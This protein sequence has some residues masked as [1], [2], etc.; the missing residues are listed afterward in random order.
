V[1]EVGRIFASVEANTADFDRKMA[2][3]ERAF[4]Q[5][6]TKMGQAGAQ[7]DASVQ[8][9]LDVAQKAYTDR[10]VAANNAAKAEIDIARRVM[11]ERIK[12]TTSASEIAAVREQY[13]RRAAAA[14]AGA[15][16]EIQAAQQAFLSSTQAMRGSITTIGQVGATATKSSVG[17]NALRSSMTTLAANALSS[18][19]G[20]AQFGSV[21]GTMALGAPAMIAILAGLAA[22]GVAVERIGR[23][24]R[25]AAKESKAAI[26]SLLADAAK[27]ADPTGVIPEL[28]A[29]RAR[30]EVLEQSLQRALNPAFDPALLRQGISKRLAVDEKAVEKI[31][32]EIGQ[33]NLAIREGETQVIDWGNSLK[34]NA[35]K[36][37]DAIE[38]LNQAVVKLL[39]A[40]IEK[41]G[42]TV[43]RLP[44]LVDSITGSGA[45]RQVEIVSDEAVRRAARIGALIREGGDSLKKRIDQ[46]SEKFD[47]LIA[48]VST[49]GGAFDTLKNLGSGLVLD[50]LAGAAVNLV[51]DLFSVSE[52]TRALEAAQRDLMNS[53]R[54]SVARM[55]AELL[56]PESLAKFDAASR[57]GDFFDQVVEN[58]GLGRA[59]GGQAAKVQRELITKILGLT[60]DFKAPEF[61]TIDEAIAFLENVFA[62]IGKDLTKEQF[63]ALSQVLEAAK[64]EKELLGLSAAVNK[65]TEALTNVPQGFKIALARFNVTQPV[66]AL[67]LTPVDFPGRPPRFDPRNPPPNMSGAGRTIVIENLVSSAPD[68][69]RLFEEIELEADRA[70]ARGGVSSSRYWSGR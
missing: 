49:I 5:T 45:P 48:K 68:A 43:G 6:A 56:G 35:E 47:D 40:E 27:R 4:Q 52:A 14:R 60:G 12:L 41:L 28:S 1:L 15:T 29:A 22:V 39:D 18:A 51:T 70:A 11:N 25:E 46:A 36:G 54:L 19:P 50:K 67:P 42:G 55:R 59:L 63:E 62:K 58:F 9:S 7:I 38:R 31:R 16:A 23:K 24:W 3:A 64:L 66:G 61:K 13:A 69:R 34:D 8:K 30:K 21:L 33:L 32:T 17:V 10:I 37:V 2:G 57:I 65:V 44:G 20:V 53:I 26:D